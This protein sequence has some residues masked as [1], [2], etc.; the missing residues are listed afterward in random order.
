ML[1]PPADA[2]A[3]PSKPLARLPAPPRQGAAW[4]ARTASH[5]RHKND[6]PGSISVFEAFSA[7]YWGRR[8]DVSA[9]PATATASG[10]GVLGGKL[11]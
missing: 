10:A 9:S 6:A 1:G 4:K 2:R 11:Q 5:Y 7:A 8:R 3:A